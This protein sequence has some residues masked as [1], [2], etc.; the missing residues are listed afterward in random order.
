MNRI[1]FFIDGFNLFHSLDN[2]PA[3]HKYKWLNLSSLAEKFT[4]KQDE[5]KSIFAKER[6]SL[7]ENEIKKIL[8]LVRKYYVE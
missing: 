8:E 7:G 4:T 1:A 3:Y 6:I 2:N 5:I